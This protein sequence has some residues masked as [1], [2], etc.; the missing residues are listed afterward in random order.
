M[1]PFRI[2]TPDGWLVSNDLG[3]LTT[4]QNKAEAKVFD[5]DERET[6]DRPNSAWEIVDLAIDEILARLN[7][8]RLPGF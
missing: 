4:S 6:Y 7:A 1:K 5:G 3:V 2:Y 8:P